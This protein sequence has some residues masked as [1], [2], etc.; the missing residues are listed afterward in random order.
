MIPTDLIC[1]LL[2][3]FDLSLL[4]FCAPPNELVSVPRTK[5]IRYVFNSYI[6]TSSN[7]LILLNTAFSPSRQVQSV[8][9]ISLVHNPRM[10]LFYPKT[11]ASIYSSASP[12]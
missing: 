3:T 11:Q 4:M 12:L 9:A 8:A 10:I 2:Q 1:A 5:C 6:L 7:F